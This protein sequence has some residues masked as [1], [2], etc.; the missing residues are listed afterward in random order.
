MSKTKIW[1]IVGLLVI[2]GIA[3]WKFGTSKD[4]ST[5]TGGGITTQVKNGI[6]NLIDQIKWW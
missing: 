6:G 5:S 1:L 4:I 2:A 3:I